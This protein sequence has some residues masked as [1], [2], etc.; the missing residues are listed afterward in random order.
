VLRINWTLSDEP[1]TPVVRFRVQELVA[2]VGSESNESAWRWADAS[3]WVSPGLRTLAVAC[4]YSL[5]DVVANEMVFSTAAD[6]PESIRVVPLGQWRVVAVTQDGVTGECRQTASATWPGSQCCVD[7]PPPDFG[8]YV[9]VD[10]GPLDGYACNNGTCVAASGR[11]YEARF[12]FQQ[13]DGVTVF[14]TEEAA[15]ANC[16]SAMPDAVYATQAE[17]Q[18]ACVAGAW[19][20]RP[21]TPPVSV[22]WY[23]CLNGECVP[24]S[25]A[26]TEIVFVPGAVANT[27]ANGS[28]YRATRQQAESDCNL[29]YQGDYNS[30]SQCQAACV[31]SKYKCV[32]TT[33]NGQTT[34]TCV[35]VADADVATALA[36]GQKVSSSLAAC[37]SRCGQDT[38]SGGVQCYSVS[39]QANYCD[40]A[41]NDIGTKRANVVNVLVPALLSQGWSNVKIQDAHNDNGYF[42]GGGYHLTTLWAECVGSA[43]AAHAITAGGWTVNKCVSNPA[44]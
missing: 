29:L 44:P 13:P 38:C 7:M 21:V 33:T 19:V 27:V 30:L 8:G 37:Q 26:Q 40:G 18:A 9:C 24:T 32:T 14:A 1:G 35:P 43:D 20:C 42:C 15:K 12:V 5:F 25:H 11:K 39:V 3:G 22:V 4:D 2:P 16:N 17:C 36:N 6:V 23:R 34:N 28:L 31:A 10:A 41:P